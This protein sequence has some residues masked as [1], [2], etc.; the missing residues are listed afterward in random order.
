ME[1]SDIHALVSAA[2]MGTVE[3]HTWTATHDRIETPDL[4]VLDLDP[5]RRCPGAP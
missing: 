5:T 2:Q 1:I 4:F 3:L